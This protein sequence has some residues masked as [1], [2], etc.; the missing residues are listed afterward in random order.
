MNVTVAREGKSSH[1]SKSRIHSHNV[2]HDEQRRPDAQNK[3]L[4]ALPLAHLCAAEPMRGA[5]CPGATLCTSS[6]EAHSMGYEPSDTT[7]ASKHAL[8]HAAPSDVGGS[9]Q[10]V[11]EC[12]TVT[13]RSSTCV[14]PR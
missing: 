11:V 3:L 1:N 6:D 12:S 13:F 2:S 9:A 4:L 5:H 8:R 7:V 10:L 14:A